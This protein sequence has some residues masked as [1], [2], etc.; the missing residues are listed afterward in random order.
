MNIN[1]P[2]RYAGPDARL[3]FFEQLE[4]RLQSMPGV[5][6]VAF[7][8][9]FP[10]RGGWG[11]SVFVDSAPNQQHDVDL[12]AVSP[13]YF[14][15]LGIPLI[16]GRFLTSQDR[17]GAPLTVVVNQAFAQSFLNGQDAVGHQVR[18]GNTAWMEIVGVVSDIRR[19]GH[20]DVIRP[21]MYIPAGQTAAYPVK[22]ADLAVRTS[23]EP[24]KLANA[25]QSEV[26]AIDKDQPITAVRTYEEIIDASVAQRRFQTFLLL[27]FAAVA[28]GLAAVGIFGV[29][30]YSVSQRT[31]E[32]GLR[33]ALGAE[34]RSIITLVF[35]QAGALI[36]AGVVLGVT[37]SFALMRYLSSQLFGVQTT[38][39]KTYA[40]AV[41]VLAAVAITA[42]LIPAARGSR[43]DPIV[44]L[45]EE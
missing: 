4:E 35:R 33:I 7:A 32:L 31:R 25:I 5:Q 12:Q 15:T 1:L 8:N 43:I 16:H 3:R 36:I 19:G 14:D 28:V 26:W 37:G 45:R 39:W 23:G 13:G 30:A 41:L 40:G 24:R 29:L 9:R 6:S 42:A 21:Q 18:R 27:M 2:P 11:G 10:M 20:S 17:T 22:I 38:D 44:A 34:P